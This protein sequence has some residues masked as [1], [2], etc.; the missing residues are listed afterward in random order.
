MTVETSLAISH[1]FA[2]FEQ[3]YARAVARCPE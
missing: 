2:D 1:S 3:M